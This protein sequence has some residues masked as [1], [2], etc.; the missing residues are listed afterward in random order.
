M[1][2]AT[3]ELRTF[4]E[5]SNLIKWLAII[6]MTV[7]HIG[8]YLFPQYPILRVIGRISFPLFLYTTVLG[9]QRTR[10]FKRYLLQLVVIG[11]ISIP[12]TIGRVNILFSLAVFALSMKDKRFFIPCLILSYFVEYGIYGFLLGWTIYFILYQDRTLGIAAFL[13]LHL[14]V[15]Q[16]IQV[17]AIFALF[18]ILMPF[19]AHLIRVPKVFGYLYYPLHLAIILFIARL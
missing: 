3:P 11:L 4:D 6:L 2:T 16:S 9:T 8:A 5:K 12:V 13:L 14:A 18:P 1:E 10:N 15:I 7:D 17:Y 19:N